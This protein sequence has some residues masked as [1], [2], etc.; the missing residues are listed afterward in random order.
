M[1]RRPALTTSDPLSA[2]ATVVDDFGTSDEVVPEPWSG[3]AVA[4][5]DIMAIVCATVLAGYVLADATSM[6][7]AATAVSFFLVVPGWALLRGVRARPCSMTLMAAVA[8]SICLTLIG[9]EVMVTKLGF[10]WRGATVLYCG[11]SAMVLV[12]DVGARR[13]Q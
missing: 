13:W 4:V 9:G 12:V 7:R 10:P 1:E 5:L 11:L 3:A 8:L 2:D 6:V